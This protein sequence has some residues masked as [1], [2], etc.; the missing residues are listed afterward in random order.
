[1]N[2]LICLGMWYSWGTDKRKDLI[3][4]VLG[5][6]FCSSNHT[7]FKLFVLNLNKA[8]QK[9]DHADFHSQSEDSFWKL[10]KGW[11]IPFPRKL[12]LGWVSS[13]LWGSS[14][15]VQTKRVYIFLISWVVARYWMPDTL[16]QTRLFLLLLLLLELFR[17]NSAISDMI[18]TV[19]IQTGTL[20]PPVTW[21]SYRLLYKHFSTILC[22]S[23]RWIPKVNLSDASVVLHL[24]PSF[25]NQSEHKLSACEGTGTTRP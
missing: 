22:A 2:N 9:R 3:V 17:R 21:V 20:V 18:P 24:L 23:I 12:S 10:T 4:S 7:E 8:K 19:N 14:E 15:V 6:L 13:H 25:F 5:S 11:N 1:M 16:K